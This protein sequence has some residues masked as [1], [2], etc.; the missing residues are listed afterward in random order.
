MQAIVTYHKSTDNGSPDPSKL[1]NAANWWK[2]NYDALSAGGPFVV[3]LMN[4]WGDHS[5]TASQYSS[6]Y[7]SAISVVRQVYNGT[8]ICD[9][10]GWGQEFHIAADASSSITD[11][12]LIFS[13]HIYPVA[14]ESF[15][16]GP[17]IKA[18]IDYLHNTG[19]KCIIGEFG[20]GGRGSTD[21]SGL[22]DYAKSKNWAVIG[23]A[24]NGDG[25]KPTKMNMA[26]PY[27][28]D[29]N[30]CKATTYSASS[31]FNTIYNKL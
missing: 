7:N 11:T 14:W 16:S 19:R 28:G 31:Y 23:W 25:S 26:S 12:N 29:K 24:W 13:A 30:G 3:N 21:W 22:V 17:P 1:M 8:I 15:Y 18:S 5:V 4:E 2:T 6:A 9:L 10:P 20:S 27:W